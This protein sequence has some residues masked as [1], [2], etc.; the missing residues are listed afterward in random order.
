VSSYKEIERPLL[1][2]FHKNAV[3]IEANLSHLHEYTPVADPKGN[4]AERR[5]AKKLS[6]KEEK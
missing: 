5:R 6:K 4:R 2:D 1:V 3:K